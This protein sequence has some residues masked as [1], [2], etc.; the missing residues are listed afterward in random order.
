MKSILKIFFLLAMSM[1]LVVFSSCGNDEP[2]ITISLDKSTL[3]LTIGEEQMLIATILPEKITN[4][5]ITWTSDNETVATVDANGKVIAIAFGTANI[6]AQADE[7]IA[8]C[9]V[10]VYDRYNDVGVEIADIIWATRNVNMPSTFVANPEDAGMFYQ[11]NSNKPWNTTDKFISPDDWTYPSLPKVG[12]EW[13][14]ENNPC[15]IGWRV[16]TREE[17]MS[18]HNFLRKETIVNGVNGCLYGNP[19][20]QI[21][22]PTIGYRYFH[23]GEL[24]WAGTA[25]GIWG[26]TINPDFNPPS[27]AYY[28]SGCVSVGYLV[29]S[30]YRCHGHSVRCVKE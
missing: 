21:F 11:W 1:T 18:L 9:R 6:T 30:S 13:E 16:P 15:P 2:D 23:N 28:L 5:T 26:S 22:L 14:K 4:K 27:N 10:T 19:P 29:G 24:R 17:L 8:T 25:V 7:K 12:R 3:S 20:N